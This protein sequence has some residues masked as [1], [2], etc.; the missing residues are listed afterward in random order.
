MNVLLPLYSLTLVTLTLPTRI[1]SVTLALAVLTSSF[2]LLLSLSHRCG[3]R[4]L[5]LHTLVLSASLLCFR[6]LDECLGDRLVKRLRL[7]SIHSLLQA[8]VPDASNKGIDD[9]LLRGP[10][11]T[12][13][14]NLTLIRQG[15]RGHVV[16]EVTL[17]A[18]RQVLKAI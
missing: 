16:N 6:G 18:A 5:S 1:S 4:T 13:V 3:G 7:L 15:I 12:T 8:T 17:R 14:T 11:L 2:R 9:E 10:N